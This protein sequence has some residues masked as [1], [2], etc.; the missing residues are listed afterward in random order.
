MEVSVETQVK[1][2]E[3]HLFDPIYKG[4]KPYN[5]SQ[6]VI[7]RGKIIRVMGDGMLVIQYLGSMRDLGEITN[8]L[9]RHHGDPSPV[10][11]QLG[12]AGYE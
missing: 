1:T 7:R 9:A 8:N 5:A 10:T 4:E 6:Y 12:F 11:K 3:L 2:D